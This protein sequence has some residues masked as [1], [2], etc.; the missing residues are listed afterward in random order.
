MPSKRNRRKEANRDWE[1][2]GTDESYTNGSGTHSVSDPV[3]TRGVG[4]QGDSNGNDHTNNQN[5]GGRSRQDKG[6]SSSQRKHKPTL[7]PWTQAVDEAVRDMG[8]AQRTIN[9]L[10]EMF[11]SHMDD[12]S[13]MDEIRRRLDQLEEE[14]REKDD[15]LE[16]QE[17]TISILTSMD[18]KARA[19]IEQEVAQIKKDKQELEQEKAKQDRRVTMATA[20]ERHNLNC[21]FEERTRQ[22]EESHKTRMQE[23]EDEFA[24]KRDENEKRATALAAEKERLSTVLKEQEKA[25]KA[26]ADELEEIKEQCD[27]LNRAKDSYKKDKLAR[28]RELEIMKKEFALNAEPPA[29]FMQRFAAIYGEIEGIS[30][31]YFHDIE[32]KD[33]EEVHK[34]LAAAD[35]CFRSVPIDDSD[36][37]HD[38]RTA[39]AQRI[40]SNAICEDIWKPLRSELTIQ[41]PEFSSF[42]SKISNELDKFSHGGRTASVWTALTMQALQSLEAN[43]VTS[44]VPESKECPHPSGSARADS[45]ISKVFSVLSPLV[46][47]SQTELLRMDLLTLVNS[48]VDVWDNAQAGGLKITV[49]PLLDRARREEW[50]SQQFDPQSPS[51]GS[52]EADL[53]LV[54]RTHPRVFTLFPRVVARGVADPGNHDRGLPGSWPPES[55]LTCIHPGVGLPEWSSLVVRGKDEQEEKKEYLIKALENAKKEL[56]ST[57]R[58]LGHGRRE[59]R[60]SSTS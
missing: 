24:Q 4:E 38:L 1:A 58:A 39:H 8:A 40:I 37:S 44:Q 11:I 3:N 28:E 54:S 15:E 33:L 9:N 50:R 29:Y 13:K 41:H 2:S 22:H 56:H 47:S 20:E 5:G 36:D 10:Q 46:S 53:E 34:E 25:F 49:S 7:G 12:L 52:D 55:D 23:L 21:E 45:V 59:S 18:R 14:N 17:H 51:S 16:K 31:K 43:L 26:Q 48:A 27:V 30:L 42:L 35:P 57:R 19:N 6:G 32:D 60:G